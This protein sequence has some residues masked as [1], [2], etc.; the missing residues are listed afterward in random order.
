MVVIL[1]PAKN[2]TVS[3][4]EGV[5]LSRP[6]F[7]ERTEELARELKT[8]SPWQLES[9]MGINP[10]LALGAFEG[11]QEFSPEGEGS[12][13]LLAYHG[14]QYQNMGPGDF[15]PEEWA[16]AQK[17]VRILSAFYGVLKPLDG[18][19]P[20]RLEF[21]CRFRPGGKTLYAYWGDTLYRELFSAGEPVMDL[22]SKEYSKGVSKYLK[23]GD[24]MIVCDFLVR[25]KGRLT[26][27]ATYAKMARGQMVRWMVQQR[28]DRPE[29]LQEFTWEGYR[30]QPT[31]SSGERYV[32]VRE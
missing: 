26:T 29:G 31:L 8:L 17:R 14:L 19:Q 11:F 9:L 32:F 12:P 3:R 23:P 6:R 1:S 22:A 28:V 7:L 27:L 16:F 13:A 20:Y 25:R 10:Q 5:P 30:F 18:I 24:R 4:L 21:Q 15:T 2:M